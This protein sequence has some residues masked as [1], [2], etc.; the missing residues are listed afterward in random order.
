MTAGAMRNGREQM[1]AT[2]RCSIRVA[3]LI[4]VLLSASMFD[5]RGTSDR[6]TPLGVD[7]FLRERRVGVPSRV[8]RDARITSGF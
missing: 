7:Y 8:E 1:H 6:G 2:R 3:P 5:S 4:A